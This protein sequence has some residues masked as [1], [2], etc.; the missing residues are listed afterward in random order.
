MVFYQSWRLALVHE[1][2]HDRSHKR[3]RRHGSLRLKPVAVAAVIVVA[4]TLVASALAAPGRI[5][6]R[7]GSTFSSTASAGANPS[8][9]FVGSGTQG[10]SGEGDG[11]SESG[12]L[13]F[14]GPS[15][16][17]VIILAFGVTF[18]VAVRRGKRPRADR[19][20]EP[21]QG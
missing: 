15:S 11:G 2:A 17:I 18:Y 16:L 19:G 10:G 9:T 1:Q 4:A 14:F 3:A 5:A 21:K 13:G 20:R 6:A 7:P 8:S 12:N